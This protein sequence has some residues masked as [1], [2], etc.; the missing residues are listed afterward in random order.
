MI[1]IKKY[2]SL[3]YLSNSFK[4][5]IKNKFYNIDRNNIGIRFNKETE[6]KLLPSKDETVVIKIYEKK[7]KFN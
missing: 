6:V 2:T 5:Q 3:Y 1:K 4:I 7:S